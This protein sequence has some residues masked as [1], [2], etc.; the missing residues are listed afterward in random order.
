MQN[1]ENVL[2]V[3]SQFVQP[4]TNNITVYSVCRYL[5]ANNVNANLKQLILYSILQN[6]NCEL[7]KI[8]K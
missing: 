7:Q 3:Y 5:S 6:L 8:V 4:F 2:Q 1:V